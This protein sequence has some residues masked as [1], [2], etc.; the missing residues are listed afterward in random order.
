M[1]KYKIEDDIMKKE[2]RKK[3]FLPAGCGGGFAGFMLWV[4]LKKIVGETMT[5]W[6]GLALMFICIAVGIAFQAIDK[7]KIKP[8]VIIRNK[9]QD[10]GEIIK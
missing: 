6:M 4:A 2:R 9:N 3:S 10:E 5:L 7:R 1:R 8:D